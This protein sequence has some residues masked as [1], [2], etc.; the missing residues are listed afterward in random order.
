VERERGGR[1][2]GF[3]TTAAGTAEVGRLVHPGIHVVTEVA[4]ALEMTIAFLAVV[5]TG[6]L[7]VVLLPLIVAGKVEAAVIAFPVGTGSTFVLLQGPVVWEVSCTAATIRHG[8]SWFEVKQV[9][10]R[11]NSISEFI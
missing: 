9:K 11:G 6:T 3:V 8:W 1:D 2:E 7:Y 4:L 5:V 10:G